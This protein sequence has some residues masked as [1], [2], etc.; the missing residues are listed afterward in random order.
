MSFSLYVMHMPLVLLLVGA[1]I[2]DGKLDADASGWGAYAAVML[3]IL[4]L[5]RLFWWLFE[6]H[7]PAWRRWVSGWVHGS[8]AGLRGALRS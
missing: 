1:L 4:V 7:A 5:A 3:V 2:R 6:R 8:A